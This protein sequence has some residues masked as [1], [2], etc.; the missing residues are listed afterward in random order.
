MTDDEINN[1]G[2]KLQE[3]AQKLVDEKA[4]DRYD[5]FEIVGRYINDD[6]WDYAVCE[7]MG[8]ASRFEVT[9]TRYNGPVNR[10]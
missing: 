8:G 2:L 7:R 3:G 10:S 9:I 5:A 6:D 1:L 4:A